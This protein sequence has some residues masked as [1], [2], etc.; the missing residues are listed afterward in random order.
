[1]IHVDHVLH[2]LKALKSNLESNVDVLQLQLAEIDKAIALA[3]EAS[4]AVR[5]QFNSEFPSP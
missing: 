5:T 2:V 3:T 1:M 4:V